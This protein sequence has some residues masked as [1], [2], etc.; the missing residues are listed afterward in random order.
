M[1]YY[2]MVTYVYTYKEFDSG[3]SL[4]SLFQ[5]TIS[6]AVESIRVR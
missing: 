1:T 4:F 6:V 5:I 3:L 2:M